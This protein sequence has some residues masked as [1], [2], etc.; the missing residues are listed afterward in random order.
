MAG[1][2]GPKPVGSGSGALS[3]SNASVRSFEVDYAVVRV[4]G[5]TTITESG[6]MYGSFDGSAWKISTQRTGD[7]G[8]DFSIT[9]LGAIE[10][11][12]TLGDGAGTITYSAKAKQQ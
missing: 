7:A 1:G 3:F 9:A 6:K 8:V 10:Y 11:Y 5:V 12:S 2:N 4:E